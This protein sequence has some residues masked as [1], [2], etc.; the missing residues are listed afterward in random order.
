MLCLSG[1]ELYPR[2]V[3]QKIEFRSTC[4]LACEQFL[5]QFNFLGNCLPTPPPSHH[6]ALGEK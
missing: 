3:P 1:F 5:D 6:F 4:S 2:W